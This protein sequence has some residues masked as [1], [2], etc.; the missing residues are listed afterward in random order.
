MLMAA[1]H[2]VFAIS[3]WRVFGPAARHLRG[4]TLFEEAA[5]PSGGEG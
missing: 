1:G 4:P 2:I 5:E 3:L